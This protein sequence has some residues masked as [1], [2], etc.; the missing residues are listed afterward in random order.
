MERTA[1][2]ARKSLLRRAAALQAEGHA[3]AGEL[4][5]LIRRREVA[6]A[7]VLAPLQAAANE[8]LVRVLQ[9]HLLRTRGLPWLA[10]V[11]SWWGRYSVR[12]S[13]LHGSEPASQSNWQAARD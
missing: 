3:A 9:S 8:R 12:H 1:D 10:H 6:E 4:A 2:E 7:A 13:H 5:G 11:C